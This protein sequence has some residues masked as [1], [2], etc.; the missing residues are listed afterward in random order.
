[1]DRGVIMKKILIALFSMLIM[2]SCENEN[3]G[4]GDEAN[5]CYMEISFMN[6]IQNKCKN[7]SQA[8]YII[9]YIDYCDIV[10][11]IHSKTHSSCS[12]K[13]DKMYETC[14]GV[15]EIETLDD[16]K[17]IE[18]C[19]NFPLKTKKD[20]CVENQR[21]YCE[22]VY[23]QCGKDKLPAVCSDFTIKESS[24]H[25][26]VIF[27]DSDLTEYCATTEN[28]TQEISGIEDIYSTACGNV[29]YDCANLTDLNFKNDSWKTSCIE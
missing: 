7:T 22:K 4:D 28:G 9:E 5:D 1:M 2:I 20:V 25:S 26:D 27:N 10:T 24:D 15:S 17:A 29:Q 3:S 12:E 18:G 21:T 6:Q 14:E 11:T 19:L 16:L 23:F 8:I 13:I